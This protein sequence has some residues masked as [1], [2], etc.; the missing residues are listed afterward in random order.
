MRREQTLLLTKV[1]SCVVAAGV[2]LYLPILID[3]SDDP[4]SGLLF[5]TLLM[6]GMVAGVPVLVSA[7]VH[8]WAGRADTWTPLVASAATVAAT[9]IL[10]SKGGR[11]GNLVPTAFVLIAIFTALMFVG[12]WVARR[13]SGGGARGIS[14]GR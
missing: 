4:E 5:L 10:L 9:I 7:V 13:V 12:V 3:E 11:P 1:I 6:S 2:L 14:A 8:G